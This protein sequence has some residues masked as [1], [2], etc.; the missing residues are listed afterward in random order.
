MKELKID[1]ELKAIIPPLSQDE[2]KQ[3]E[4]NIKEEGCREPLIVWDS[5]IIDGHNRYIICEE[6]GID[7]KTGEKQFKNKDEAKVWIIDNQRGRRNLTDGWKW[8]LAQ[9]KKKLLQEKGKETQGKR[10]DLLSNI[11][12][13]FS[14]EATTNTDEKPQPKHNTRKEIANELGWSSSKTAMADKVWNEAR[15]ETKEK[16]KS[17]DLTFNQAYKQVKQKEKQQQAKK[18]RQKE[19]QKQKE[20]NIVFPTLLEGDMFEQLDQI[21]ENSIDLLNTDPPYMVLGDEWDQFESKESY[22]KFTEDWLLKTLPKL[23]KSG[24]AYISFAPDYQFNIYKIFEKN[25]FFD[26]NF[27]NIIIWIKRNNNK[28]FDRKR[29]RLTYEPIFYLYGKEAKNLNLT[30][31]TFGETQTDVWEI[32]TPQSNFKEGKEFSAQKPLELYRRIIKTGSYENET[33]LD[34][35]AGSGT[36]GIVCKEQNR[37]CILMEKDKESLKILKSRVYGEESK[38]K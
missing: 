35:F 29:Y 15:P 27:G 25:N 24:R 32:A 26:L 23:K 14:S 16:V 34:T 21:E 38:T 6:L 28:K 31:D 37:K 3:L 20:E 9:A 18:K 10:T 17:G 22:L 33:V 8:E 13:K 7:F 4:K 1:K 5:T 2:Y 30:N 11:D 19:I 12:K 36:T